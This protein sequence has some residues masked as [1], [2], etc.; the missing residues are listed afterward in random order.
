MQRIVYFGTPSV[1]VPPLRALHAA[2]FEIPLVITGV[3]KRRGRGKALQPSAV[4]QVAIELGL[5]VSADVDDALDVQADLGVVVAYGHIIAPHVLDRLPMVNLHFSLLPRW[6]GAAPV[7]RALLAGDEETGVCLMALADGLDEGDVYRRVAVPIGDDATL[8]SLRNELVDIGSTVLVDA[9]REGLGA[10]TAQEGETTYAR[11][12]TSADREIDWSLSAHQVR[13]VVALG[14]AHTSFRGR[15][16]KVWEAAISPHCEFDASPGSIVVDDEGRLL[17]T[18]GSGC[19]AL[20]E[21]QIEGKPRQS[22][23]QWRNGA[24]LTDGD[25]LGG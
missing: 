25:R 1:A 11:K 14:G 10:P 13:R 22:I 7:E 20:L 2:G 17:V 24:R 6:R 23:D 3:D 16:F 15:R 21:V 4:K 19:L 9:L 12:I 5:D 18:T 8:D